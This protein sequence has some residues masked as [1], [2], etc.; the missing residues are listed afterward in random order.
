MAHA[1]DM[2]IDELIEATMVEPDTRQV[3][4]KLADLMDT[5]KGTPQW[6]H[7]ME[8]EDLFG[9]RNSERE[10]AAFLAGVRFASDPMAFVKSLRV[11]V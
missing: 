1:P 11:H 3:S 5:F 8:L 4:A 7:I 9:L 2:T 6:E 10:R